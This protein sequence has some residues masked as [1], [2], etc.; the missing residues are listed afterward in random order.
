MDE[1]IEAASSGSMAA[2]SVCLKEIVKELNKTDDD[3]AS[4]LET[5]LEEWILSKSD[6]DFK[7]AKYPVTRHYNESYKEGFNAAQRFLFGRV[8]E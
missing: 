2:M 4:R 5:A 1:H 7:F 6:E 3:F 8:V